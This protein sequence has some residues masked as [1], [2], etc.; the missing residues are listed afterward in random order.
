[1]ALQ[2]WGRVSIV[3]LEA[4]GVFSQHI[5]ILSSFICVRLRGLGCAD[6]LLRSGFRDLYGEQ[7][8]PEESAAE[9]FWQE[10][11]RNRPSNFHSHICN[12]YDICAYIRRCMCMYIYIERERERERERE[13]ARDR[14][15][16]LHVM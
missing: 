6:V 2:A 11:T 16:D 14:V 13:G 3:G 12:I 15:G 10:A 8:V 5:R 9:A 1:M 4:N 7:P